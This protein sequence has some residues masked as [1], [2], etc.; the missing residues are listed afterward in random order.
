[1]AV[2]EH[3][4]STV[5]R[6]F[7]SCISDISK[8]CK[9]L[10]TKALEFAREHHSGQRRKSG[11]PYIIHP[12]AVALRVCQKYNDPALT[13]AALLHDTVED[14][15]NVEIDKIYKEFG[16][17]IG[18]LVD[19]VTKCAYNFYAHEGVHFEDRVE[20]L[21]WAGLQDVRVLLLKIADRENNL[22]T[23]KDLKK[24]KQVRMAFETQAIYK[25]LKKVV[26]Y[27]DDV[28]VAEAK[29]ARDA[30]MADRGISTPRELKDVLVQESFTNIDSDMFGIIYKDSQ[31]IVW[32]ITSKQT[33]KKLCENE[34]LRNMVRFLSVEGNSNW[35]CATFKF[36]KGVIIE[37]AKFGISSYQTEG[38]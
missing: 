28:T 19:A 7:N 14:C 36:V 26:R 2:M 5:E 24:N 16:D 18:F 32:K 6:D 21:L 1:M 10:I 3:W 17:E 9:D 8:D 31:S 23:I 30:F 37:D 13:A 29:E 33:Y 22:K 38:V 25:P 15:E 35:F 27:D 34:S 12:V 20:R 4:S 11:E